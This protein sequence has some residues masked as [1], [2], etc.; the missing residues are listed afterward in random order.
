MPDPQPP[1]VND[2]NNLDELRLLLQ[3]LQAAGTTAF[4]RRRWTT[5]VR[6]AV[7]MGVF[8]M[9][10]ALLDAFIMFGMH[11]PRANL[12]PSSQARARALLWDMGGS[13]QVALHPEDFQFINAQNQIVLLDPHNAERYLYNMRVFSD[14]EFQEWRDCQMTRIFILRYTREAW[15]HYFPRLLETYRKTP[16]PEDLMPALRQIT[17]ATCA[18]FEDPHDCDRRGISFGVDFNAAAAVPAWAALT[19]MGDPRLIHHLWTVREESQAH[20]WPQPQ[21]GLVQC[22]LLHVPTEKV[23][24]GLAFLQTLMT[25]QHQRWHEPIFQTINA[26]QEPIVTNEPD[27]FYFDPTNVKHPQTHTPGIAAAVNLQAEG[28]PA[29]DPEIADLQFQRAFSVAMLGINKFMAHR[30]YAGAVARYRARTHVLFRITGPQT[31][32]LERRLALSEFNNNN[33]NIR[34]VRRFRIFTDLTWME[35]NAQLAPLDVQNGTRGLTPAAA[36]QIIANSQECCR[37]HVYEWAERPPDMW[38]ALGLNAPALGLKLEEDYTKWELPDNI[39]DYARV[40]HAG[41]FRSYA[42]QQYDGP[43]P[44]HTFNP[45]IDH[46]DRPLPLLA[47]P[48]V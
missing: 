14:A 18:R 33:E 10:Q 22:L 8:P 28:D 21:L 23:A 46:F 41:V 45:E 31:D 43:D 38:G 39:I 42:F 9:E 35:C 7:E 29:A 1:V 2:D 48:Y 16:V 24:V 26:E 34:R 44:R 5:W 15:D 11:P 32:V 30:P 27:F 25:P 6:R 36:Q 47:L 19:L 37:V 13:R 20:G 3:T 40:T 17:A 4:T 12:L